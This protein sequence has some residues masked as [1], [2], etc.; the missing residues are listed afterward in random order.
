MELTYLGTLRGFSRA[1]AL[2]ALAELA[3]N[4]PDEA[5]T[6]VVS[7][8][9]LGRVLEAEPLLIATLVEIAILETGIQPL[10]EGLAR[11][12]WQ[13]P[14]LAVFEKELAKLDFVAGMGRTLRFERV[15]SLGM[16]EAWRN[17]PA[18]AG[19]DGVAPD[20][21]PGPKYFPGGWIRQSQ[22]HIARMFQDFLIPVLDTNRMV[23]DVQLGNRLE[24][25]A[26]ARLEGWSP[27]K[28]MARMLFPAINRASQ[29]AAVAQNSVNQ[30][31]IAVAL[32]RFRLAHGSYPEA[33]AALS[34]KFLPVL[35][36]DVL[37][38]EPHRYQR[39]APDR[40]VLYA[41]GLNLK[42][43]AG[44]VAV[45]KQGRP[46]PRAAAGDWVWQNFAVTNTVTIT[47]TER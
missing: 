14:Q 34:P 31:R 11:H 21:V 32:E 26:K 24:T 41:V 43:D 8:L 13:E 30:A 1:L 5:A 28:V 25:E 33:L 22:V 4:H 47:T 37:T 9:R 29:G 23:V 20:F 39:E 2:K 18:G 12:E 35:P 40:F 16:L 44:Q 6:D 3:A 7:V 38:G 19:V 27:Y 46:N 17:P 36:H 10:W 15:F 42:D 45:T